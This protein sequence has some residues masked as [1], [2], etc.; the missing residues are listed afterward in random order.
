MSKKL[1]KRVN[2]GLAIY[3]GIGSLITAVMSVV[4]FLVMIYKAV[5]LNGNYNWELYFIPIIGLMIAGTMAY[6]LLRI[7]YEE[8]EN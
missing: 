1:K 3:A 7:G 5:F 4:G 8:L 2:G 6:I